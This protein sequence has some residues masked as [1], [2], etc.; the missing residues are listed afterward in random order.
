M[1]VPLG[2]AGL[3]RPGYVPLDYH[4]DSYIHVQ[5]LVAIPGHTRLFQST[6]VSN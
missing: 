4:P 2:L 5:S 6:L 1:S 3:D